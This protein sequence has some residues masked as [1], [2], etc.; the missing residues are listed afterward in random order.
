MT[1][2]LA[3]LLDDLGASSAS[4][5]IPNLTTPREATNGA[6]C[7]GLAM[8]TAGALWVGLGYTAAFLFA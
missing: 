8:L 1:N 7:L 3:T 5:G 2:S 6:P 4:A